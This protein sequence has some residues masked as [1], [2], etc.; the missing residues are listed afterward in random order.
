MKTYF[1]EKNRNVDVRRSY[2]EMSTMDAF[3]CSNCNLKYEAQVDDDNTFSAATA[4]AM[5]SLYKYYSISKLF[6][7]F[8]IVPSKKEIPNNSFSRPK[9][10]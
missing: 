3:N 5:E 1:S 4:L 7:N 6:N 2:I 9:W 8:Q 10:K